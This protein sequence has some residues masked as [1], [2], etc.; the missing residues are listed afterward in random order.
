MQSG[1]R[2]IPADGGT[3]QRYE[4]AICHTYEQTLSWLA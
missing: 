3:N 1:R 2:N 4:S